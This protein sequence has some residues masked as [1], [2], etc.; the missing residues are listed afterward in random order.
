MFKTIE[1][2]RQIGPSEKIPNDKHQITNK[3]KIRKNN[4][5]NNRDTQASKSEKRGNSKSQASNVE[6]QNLKHQMR[7]FKMTSTK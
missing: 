7:K 2:R 6:I 4:V 1:T 3:F 5:Q